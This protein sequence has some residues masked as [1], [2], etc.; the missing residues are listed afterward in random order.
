VHIKR[1]HTEKLEKAGSF[2]HMLST[3]YISITW[4]LL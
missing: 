4:D 3:V 2:L 1:R